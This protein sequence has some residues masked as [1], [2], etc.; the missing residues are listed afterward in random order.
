MGITMSGVLVKKIGRR[1]GNLREVKRVLQRQGRL[2]RTVSDLDLVLPI[3]RSLYLSRTVLGRS[4][5]SKP[6]G[7]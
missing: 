4:C 7:H 3:V 5:P 1:F 6:T 2:A